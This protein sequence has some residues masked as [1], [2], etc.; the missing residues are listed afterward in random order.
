[1]TRSRNFLRSKQFGCIVSETLAFER[2]KEYRETRTFFTVTVRQIFQNLNY[3]FKRIQILNFHAHLHMLRVNSLHKLHFIRVLVL[4]KIPSICASRRHLFS[5]A[6]ISSKSA[7][8]F[9]G[10]FES[11]LSK[12][13]RCAQCQCVHASVLVWTT[14]RSL[15]HSNVSL[16]ASSDP[17]INP[18]INLCT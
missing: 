2:K 12:D 16:N 18:T 4:T 10:V 14:K 8:F 17:T 7:L 5:K 6:R 9:V 11:A 15:A 13:E 3:K 1:M